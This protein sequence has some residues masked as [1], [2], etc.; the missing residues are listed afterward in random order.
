[1]MPPAAIREMR[2]AMRFNTKAGLSRMSNS[3]GD[4]CSLIFSMETVAVTRDRGFPYQYAQTQCSL[5]AMTVD[6]SVLAS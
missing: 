5:R 2:I 3:Q 6:F 4:F 1:M